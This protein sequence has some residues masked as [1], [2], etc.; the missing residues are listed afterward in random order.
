MTLSLGIP[1]SVL[2]A[3]R[4]LAQAS[5]SQAR[6]FERLSSG[7]R[8][9]SPSDDPAGL[10][11][12]SKLES[13]ARV[14]QRARL[15]VADGT[16]YLT[17]AD[18]ALGQVSTLLGRMV[19][20]AGQAANG[21][22]SALQRKTLSKE[23]ESLD[24]EIRRLVGATAFN[25]AT[26][27]TG[28]KSQGA[29]T[30]VVTANLGAVLNPNISRNERFIAYNEAGGVSSEFLVKDTLTGEI[31]TLLGPSTSAQIVGVTD[32]GDVLF[33]DSDLS[34]Y[35]NLARY[36]F[37]SNSITTLSSSSDVND[38]VAVSLSADGNTLAFVSETT[39]ANGGSIGSATGVQNGVQRLYT[40]DLATG[41]VRTNGVNLSSLVTTSNRLVVS[42]DGSKV[43]FRTASHGT[44]V[45]DYSNPSAAFQ[46]ITTFNA[47]LVGIS[48]D[49]DLVFS[50]NQNVTG[51]GN[52]VNQFFQYSSSTGA[53]S[54]L[55]SFAS[56]VSLAN[57]QLSADGSIIAFRSSGNI[58]GE[59]ASGVD[60]YF[61]LDLSL[62]Q[63]EQL[64]NISATIGIT[65]HRINADSTAVYGILGDDLVK[66]DLSATDSR[67]D[68]EVG[69]GAAGN[70]A[71]SF[72]AVRSALR[73]IGAF[74]L[75]SS[76]F[77]QQALDNGKANIEALS[78][79]R[80][81]IGAGLS[82][83]TS[84]EGLLADQRLEL[85]SARSRIVDADVAAESAQLLA[86][87]ILLQT[88]SAVLAQAK[89]SSAL[90]LTL[91]E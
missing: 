81:V 32:S 34:T 1:T 17:I 15:N 6:S 24:R 38:F 39:Y 25:G 49:G 69:F 46:S 86:T 66:I 89:N 14:L 13:K 10:S 4:R 41:L 43:G 57:A 16:S 8:I 51:N 58:T 29:T 31:R 67:V 22:L 35:S 28:G 59:N 5:N 61:R 88:S 30:T 85:T 45:A 65:S 78:A 9:N 44:F 36:S 53:I 76:A 20:L 80:G 21:S 3:Q 71:V 47:T 18:G 63:F 52:S 37:S 75:Y 54:Q 33:I 56:S 70:I 68:L 90:V 26:L 62:G 19:E 2:N 84:A 55:T 87:Q 77:A 74:N 40:L 83:L 73:G 27:L 50:S 11:V 12:S 79:I 60:Q 91:L 72:D 23:Y 64:T 7:L 82:R 42:S 48:S